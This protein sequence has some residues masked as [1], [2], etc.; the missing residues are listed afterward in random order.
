MGHSSQYHCTGIVR[1]QLDILFSANDCNIDF[2]THHVNVASSRRL[3]DAMP[4]Q[5]LAKRR[6]CNTD[7]MSIVA[8]VWKIWGIL[9]NRS[10]RCLLPCSSK[11]TKMIERPSQ[12]M[13]AAAIR[14]CAATVLLSAVKLFVASGPALSSIIQ[15]ARKRAVPRLRR[16]DDTVDI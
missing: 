8:G 9:L 14:S 15:P 2:C 10:F 1:T 12:A 16:H 6:P 7:P 4:K 13:A 5:V 3:G 11:T